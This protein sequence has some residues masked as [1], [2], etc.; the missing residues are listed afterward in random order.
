MAALQQAVALAEPEGYVNLFLAEGAAAARLLARAA[1]AGVATDYV[2]QLRTALASPAGAT[3]TG[4]DILPDPLSDREL[5]I[6]T[7]I[8]SGRKNKEIA[9]TLFVSVN[10]VHYHT[11]NLYSKLGVNSRTQAITRANELNLLA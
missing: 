3:A 8:A 4:P 7:L 5:E 11:K 2:N 1:S 6:L 10:T 9:A